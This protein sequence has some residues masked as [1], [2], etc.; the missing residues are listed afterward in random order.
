MSKYLNRFLFKSERI[1]RKLMVGGDEI[2]QEIDQNDETGYYVYD[3]A[4]IEDLIVIDVMEIVSYFSVF[5]E[6]VL[7]PIFTGVGIGYGGYE[8]YLFNY[9]PE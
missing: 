8:L 5:V 9:N 1:A 7:M 4:E 2:F 6:M 3:F